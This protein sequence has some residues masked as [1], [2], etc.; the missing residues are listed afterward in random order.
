MWSDVAQA[1]THSMG[2]QIGATW[3]IRLMDASW[4]QAAVDAVSLAPPGQ[5]G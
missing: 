4:M 5:Y 1:T 3:P 2:V